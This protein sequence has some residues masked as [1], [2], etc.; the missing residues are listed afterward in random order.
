MSI[1]NKVNLTA[2]SATVKKNKYTKT[3]A[4]LIG[5]TAEETFS[6]LKQ[7]KAIITYSTFPELSYSPA[8]DCIK[9]LNILNGR[10]LVT[11]PLIG[12]FRETMVAKY[13]GSTVTGEEHFNNYV[14]P[15]FFKSDGLDGL[16]SLFDNFLSDGK[17]AE[18]FD[19]SMLTDYSAT[20]ELEAIIYG[21]KNVTINFVTYF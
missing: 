3:F 1:S 10:E 20:E 7:G 2:Q 17:S 14:Y 4:P 19:T 6:L 8:F 9:Y 18:E 12:F 21:G 13:F 15:T 11:F 16:V 5:A